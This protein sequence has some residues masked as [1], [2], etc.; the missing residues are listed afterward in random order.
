MAESVVNIISDDEKVARVIFSPSYICN[1]RVSPTAFRWETLP[2][3]DAEDYISV[4]RCNTE[5]NIDEQTK[6]FRTRTEGDSR[7]GYAVLDTKSIRNVKNNP[8][9]ENRVGI[10]VL[11]FPSKRLPNHAG[12][13]VDINHNRV[14]ANTLVTP[15]L[16]FIQKM[17]AS[18]C[19]DII[20]F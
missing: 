3:G 5:V 1:G 4:L 19:G 7:Y 18:I 12:I 8:V 13:V 17:L 9:F 2:S 20:K 10:D 6:Y 14:T 15:E 11:P 16:M